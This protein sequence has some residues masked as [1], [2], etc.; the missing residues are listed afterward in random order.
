MRR[1]SSVLL[2]LAAGVAIGCTS[3]ESTRTRAGGA[4]ADVGN[5]PR[6][7]VQIHAGDDIYYATRTHGAGIGQRAI[8]GGTQL[9]ER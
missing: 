2:L 5:H 3:P 9:V 4:G 8:I 7:P 1:W 6:G